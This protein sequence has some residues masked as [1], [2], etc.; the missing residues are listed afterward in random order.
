MKNAASVAFIFTQGWLAAAHSHIF[1]WF[2]SYQI[3]LCCKPTQQKCTFLAIGS[4]LFNSNIAIDV[5]VKVYM[6][7]L[8]GMIS[9]LGDWL[10]GVVI[11]LFFACWRLS[12][13]RGAIEM[14][15]IPSSS[16]IRGGILGK[17]DPISSLPSNLTFAQ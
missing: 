2:P 1:K 7:L 13:N 14:P 4:I 11:G 8:D 10:H 17:K 15:A 5:I 6:V 12:L 16:S 9:T 3:S